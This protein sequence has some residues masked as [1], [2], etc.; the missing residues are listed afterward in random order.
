MPI[1]EYWADQF[2][3]RAKI[4]KLMCSIILLFGMCACSSGTVSYP[5]VAD[6]DR[7][8]Q[9]VLTPDERRKAIDDMALENDQLRAKTIENIEKR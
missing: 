3:K 8:T 1:L 9:K 4:A 2:F 7:I 6:I 5:S